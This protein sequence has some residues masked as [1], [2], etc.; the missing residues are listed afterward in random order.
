MYAEIEQAYQKVFAERSFDGLV[1]RENI[2]DILSEP[3]FYLYD[4][5]NQYEISELSGGERAIFPM[6]MDFANWNIH[7]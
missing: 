1:P 3:W 5:K 4:S 2:D 6:L 7:N